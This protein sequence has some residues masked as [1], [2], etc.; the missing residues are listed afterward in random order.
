[1]ADQPAPPPPPPPPSDDMIV[2]ASFVPDGPDEDDEAAHTRLAWTVL[3]LLLLLLCLICVG[4][5]YSD[6]RPSE[7]PRH[8]YVAT[9]ADEDSLLADELAKS[10][11]DV[12]S[13]LLA[14]RRAAPASSA[15]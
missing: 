7:L 6:R 3:L 1:M 4:L 15:A 14:L 12:A 9:A 13:L 5:Q 2:H 11:F 10:D 8:V